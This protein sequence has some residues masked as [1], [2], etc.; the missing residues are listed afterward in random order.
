MALSRACGRGASLGTPLARRFGW[1][2]DPTGPLRRA[3]KPSCHIPSIQLPSIGC[4]DGRGTCGERR[5]QATCSRYIDASPTPY[6]AVAEA[7]AGSSPPASRRRTRSRPGTGCRPR[8]FLARDGALVAWSVPDGAPAAAPFR[9]VGAHT[10]SPNLR[11]KPQP[12]TGRA[13]WRQL[14]VEVYGGALLNSWLDR[15]LGLSGR[16]AVRAERAASRCAWSGSTGRCCGCRSWPSTST[17]R[18]ASE[19]LQLD[20]PAAPRPGVGR[21]RGPSPAASPASWPSEL[22]VEADDVLAWDVMVHDLTPGAFLGRD[23]R[24]RS[25]AP[26]STTSAP[27]MPRSPRCAGRDRRPARSPVVSPVRPRGGREQS[28][29]GADGALPRHRARAARPWPGAATVRTTSGRSPARS[30]SRPTWPTPPTRTTPSAT[31]PTTRS[32]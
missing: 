29:T 19:G 1:S 25:S 8:G 18:S 26:G 15:D 9:I 23:R 28:A 12:D 7:S 27:A 24:A 4:R 13:G 32:R 3:A 10:D 16:V 11:I 6:H 17:A 5:S 30:A 2:E 14:G 22:G 20:P 21:R 31:S